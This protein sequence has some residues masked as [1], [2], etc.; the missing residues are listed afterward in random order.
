MS[1]VRGGASAPLSGDRDIPL[2]PPPN[3]PSEIVAA[4]LQFAG[5]DEVCAARQAAADSLAGV[6]PVLANVLP[7]PVS[8]LEGELHATGRVSPG[9]LPK[10]GR[11]SWTTANPSLLAILTLI[12]SQ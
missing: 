8:L 9:P 12:L 6:P 5:A 7:R 2:V 4:A 3:L 11:G 1:H 10:R